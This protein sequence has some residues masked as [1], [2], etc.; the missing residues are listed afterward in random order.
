ME[1]LGAL[2]NTFYRLAGKKAE[3]VY[4][5]YEFHT[6]V[7]RRHNKWISHDQYKNYTDPEHVF[8]KNGDCAG[9]AVCIE[10]Q[11]IV[12]DKDEGN[13]EYLRLKAEGFVL[14]GIYE[15]DIFGGTRRIK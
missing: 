4:D 5:V 3:G 12:Y 14:I 7:D 8:D 9:T 13:R 15:Q 2:S 11:R 10:Y 6:T 1:K